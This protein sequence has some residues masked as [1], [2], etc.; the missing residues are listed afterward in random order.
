[1]TPVVITGA[2]VVTAIAHSA[3]ELHDVLCD[4]GGYRPGPVTTF[5]TAGLACGL[6]GV[7]EP[8]VLER[9]L[10]GRPLA[11][12]DKTGQLAIVAGQ[13]A[14]AASGLDK[15]PPAELGLVLGTMFSSAHTIGEFDRRAQTAGP[16]FASPLDFANT[17]LNAA[18]GQAAI[19]LAL[20]GVNL[21]IGGGQTAGLQAL[22][23]A[24]DLVASGRA[25]ALLAGG[26]EQLF[27]ESY[28]GHCRAGLACGTN[29]RPGHVPV[30]F[31]VYRTGLCLGEGA[32]LVMLETMPAAV[33]R[34]ATIHA[35][36]AAYSMLTDPDALE[37]GYC[38]RQVIADAI[39]LALCRAGAS[40]ADLDAV[41]AAANGSWRGDQ[42]EAEALGD[43]FADVGMPPVTAIKS[44]LGEMLG[45]SGPVQ[46]IAMIEAMRSARLPGIRGLSDTAN[47]TRM[48][49]VSAVARD[50]R[51]RTA[52]VTAI[53]AE[54]SCCALVLRAHE[55]RA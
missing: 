12:I 39:R 23:F 19:R 54:G 34:G 2:G 1:M 28:I 46:V 4:S 30:P 3:A 38:G 24:A 50:M 43:V 20:R 45:A 25:P 29:G 40:P 11:A 18:A 9:A 51:I 42:E 15:V 48:P 36:V 21:T 47:A 17:V 5:S 49:N 13:R 10:A 53:S 8:E 35:E 52:L 26:V 33:G 31:D 55:A 16:E 44:V 22:G 6:G 27:L 41:S 37:N 32:G 14:L 7:V